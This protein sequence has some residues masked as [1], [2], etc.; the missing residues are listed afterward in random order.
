MNILNF[1][2]VAL[3]TALVV[4]AILAVRVLRCGYRATEGK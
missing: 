3:A 2:L 4:A 1:P